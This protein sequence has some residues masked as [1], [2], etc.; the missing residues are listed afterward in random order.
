MKN[1]E[2]MLHSPTPTWTERERWQQSVFYISSRRFQLEQLTREGSDAGHIWSYQ[3]E[4]SLTSYARKKIGLR[5]TSLA[6]LNDELIYATWKKS[7]PGTIFTDVINI[8][9]H[10]YH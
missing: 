10:H 9:S 8:L 1:L 5:P 7:E 6:A 3:E 2:H 4:A